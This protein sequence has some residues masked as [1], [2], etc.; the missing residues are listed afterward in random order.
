MIAYDDTLDCL[1]HQVLSESEREEEATLQAVLLARKLGAPSSLGRRIA[2]AFVSGGSR[3]V[4]M[5][6]CPLADAASRALRGCKA[7]DLL[8]DETLVRGMLMHRG[9]MMTAC[10]MHAACMLSAC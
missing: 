1:P 9:G 8:P 3:G 6:I 5:G 7:L 10:C 2:D 4:D